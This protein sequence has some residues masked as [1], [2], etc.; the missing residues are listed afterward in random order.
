MRWMGTGNKQL[1][2]GQ[3]GEVGPGREGAQRDMQS[4]R[5]VLWHKSTPKR[6]PWSMLTWEQS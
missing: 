5:T 4:Q 2:D 3:V 1:A 6:R